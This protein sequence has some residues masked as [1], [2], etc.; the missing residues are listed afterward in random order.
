M[1]DMPELERLGYNQFF[2]AS[3]LA[4][5]ATTDQVARVTAEH[6]GVYEVAGMAGAFRASVTGKRI[7][8]ATSRD[9]FPAV[10]DWVVIH[11]DS[12]DA[13]LIVDILPRKTSLHKKRGGK[14]ES[15][16][17]AANVDVVFIVESIDRDYSLNRFERYLVLAKEG[18]MKP[19]IILNKSDLSND[20][21]MT[22]SVV[23]IRERFGE[24]EIITTSIVNDSG[25]DGL[26]GYI[27][28]GV[29]Y[30]FVGSSG[31]GKSSLINKLLNQD[32]ITTTAISE[33]TGRGVHT[34]TSREM[35][36]TATG[37]IIIDNPGSREVGVVNARTGIEEVFADIEAL[38]RTCKFV[39]CKHIDEFGCAV[40]EAI[41]NGALDAAQYANYRK[42]K[43]EASR[44]HLTVHARRQNDKKFGRYVKNAKSELN[45]FEAD[46]IQDQ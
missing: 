36:V 27:K 45:K 33:K 13:K 21:D 42:M 11:D 35:Y 8:N 41:K 34:T 37:G 6:K 38:A 14:D 30:C 22:K 18:G 19:V 7:L 3:K 20:H 10:G 4:R 26:K 43:K 39:D 40:T 44:N 15:Q 23:D 1:E 9:D 28:K 12:S 32:S 5:D 29:T 25:L 31:V 2:D 17:I 16:L 46:S 24:V